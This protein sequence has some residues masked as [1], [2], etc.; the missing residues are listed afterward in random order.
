[1]QSQV[2]V[3]VDTQQFLGL[4]SF[5]K[6]NGSTTDPVEVIGLAIGYWMENAEWKK[7]DLIAGIG[8]DARGYSWKSVFLPSGT[9][10][11]IKYE[12][13]FHY[14]KVEG[15]HPMYD[16][17]AVSPNQ[18]AFKVTGTPR[19]AWRDLWVKRPLDSDY[20]L[21]DDLRT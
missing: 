4:S 11:R 13:R 3:P 6:A 1:M 9:V 7:G 17:K 12:G 8:S 14:S 5:L 18:F 15:D 10:L 19:D 16:G 20:Q 21:A 2:S